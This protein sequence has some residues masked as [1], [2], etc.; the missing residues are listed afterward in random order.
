MTIPVVT[1][2]REYRHYCTLGSVVLPS[3]TVLKSIE[4]PWL[5]NRSNVSCIPEGEYLSKWL[6]RSV[7]GKYR[8]VWHVQNVPGRSGILWHTGNLVSHSRGCILPGL[9]HG[10]LNGQDAVLSSLT[11]LQVMRRELGSRDFKLIV[12]SC[13]D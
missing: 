4:R 6:P 2:V 8:R 12:T 7:S 5:N 11:G 3:G 1:L 9:R 13:S 10:L